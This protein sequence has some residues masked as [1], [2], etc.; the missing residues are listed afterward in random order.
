MNWIDIPTQRRTELMESR[1]WDTAQAVLLPTETW[2]EMGRAMNKY[3]MTDYNRKINAILV[4]QRCIRRRLKHKYTLAKEFG[5][6]DRAA[7]VKI[8]KAK[9][10]QQSQLMLSGGAFTEAEDTAATATAATATATA[11]SPQ[12]GPSSDF[13][14]TEGSITDGA[15]ATGTS[16]VPAGADGPTLEQY[17]RGEGETSPELSHGDSSSHRERLCQKHGEK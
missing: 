2:H 12:K 3:Y 6:R 5:K 1:Y 10:H 4:M 9:L 11:E 13:F 17:M 14:L 7:N 15:A 8:H 16:S